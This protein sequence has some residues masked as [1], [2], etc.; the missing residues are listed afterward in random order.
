MAFALLRTRPAPGRAAVVRRTGAHKSR[1]IWFILPAIVVLVS[2]DAGP[3]LYSLKASLTHWMLTD[4][5]SEN[6]PA[7]LSNYTDVLGSAE[8]WTAVR[9]T[10][11]YAAGSV[12]GGL[13]LGLVFALL[14]NLDFFFRPFFRSIMMI[15]MVV[16]PVVIGIFWKLLYEQ[17]SGVFNWALG[18]L[19]LPAVAWLS[20]HGA[21]PSAILMDI[22]HGTP[23]FMLV[24]LAGLQSIDSSQVEAAS[25][26]GAT[27]PQVFRHVL[28]P[29]LLPYMLIAASFRVIASMSEFDKVWMLTGG[30]PGTATTTI[31]LYTFE[32]G[33]NA[34]DIGRVASIA[35]IFVAVVITVSSPL[36]YHLFRVA[37]AE[38]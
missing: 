6:D 34:F 22:W 25:I 13:L 2:V 11:L 14:L 28:L 18:A 9:T 1:A 33:F 37:Q 24:I 38:R 7:G 19:G 21:L 32:T 23:F 10:V 29:H 26:D 16:T 35:W 3:M 36:L 27:W 31:T 8:F 20:P 15:P 12:T 17:Q 4:P 5:G 30:G